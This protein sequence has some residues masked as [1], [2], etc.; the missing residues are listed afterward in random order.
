M[1]NYDLLLARLS[2]SKKLKTLT[3][4]AFIATQKAIEPKTSIIL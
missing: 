2:L 4:I 3:A 1:T